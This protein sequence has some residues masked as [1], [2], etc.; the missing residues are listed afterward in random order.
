MV[1]IVTDAAVRFTSPGFAEKH[2]I[3]LAPV[4]VHC[5]QFQTSDGPERD[6]RE[7]RPL[8][9]SCDEPPWV[10]PPSVEHFADIYA[11]L[12]RSTS[13]VLSIHTASGLTSTYQNAV[14][15]SQ[16]FRGRMDIQV[17]DSGSMSLGL[18]LIV[19]AA[20]RAAA[21]GE[22]LD[23]LVRLARG[24]MPRLYMVFFLEDLFFL[25]RNGLISR[26][27]AILGNMLGIIPFLTMEEGSL[28]PMEKVRS[29]TRGIDK[30]VE[31]VCEFSSVEY[32]GLLH[33]HSQATSETKMVIERLRLLYPTVPITPVCYG[34][35]ASTYLGFSGFGAVVLE[36]EDAGL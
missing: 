36:H 2:G 13:E 25:E 16:Q 3:R 14:R 21:R 20:A 30:L 27:Q 4:E 6:L 8:L 33:A 17:I 15:A 26:S 7:I 1:G 29:R 9:E 12:G 23:E 10:S 5:G 32:L 34:P 22:S 28:I 19:Q 24:I 11:E 31:F 35:M 18:G